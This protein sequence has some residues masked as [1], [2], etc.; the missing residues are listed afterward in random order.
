[1]PTSTPPKPSASSAMNW[2]GSTGGGRAKNGSLLSTHRS[3]TAIHSPGLA[4]VVWTS[5]MCFKMSVNTSFCI[6]SLVVIRGNLAFETSNIH[7]ELKLVN[8]LVI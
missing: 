7:P 1:M 4:I 3:F 2:E 5:Y 8:K 6:L